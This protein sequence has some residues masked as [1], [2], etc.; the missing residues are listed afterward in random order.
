MNWLDWLASS[1]L[2]ASSE[3]QVPFLRKPEAALPRCCIQLLNVQIR[4]LSKYHVFNLI[5]IWTLKLI[6]WWYYEQGFEIHWKHYNIFIFLPRLPTGADLTALLLSELKII[7]M[8]WLFWVFRI[9]Y[10]NFN[11]TFRA[12][13]N[14]SNSEKFRI[15]ITYFAPWN[16]QLWWLAGDSKL[17]RR[18]FT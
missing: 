3:L 12:K 15:V 8:M 6:S 11:I 17:F 16:C 13:Y 10:S 7:K 9:F 4:S 5:M 2:V 18:A 1:E 14:Y